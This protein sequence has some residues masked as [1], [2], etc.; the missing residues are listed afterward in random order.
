MLVE[1][2]REASYSAGK[3]SAHVGLV[4]EDARSGRSHAA[5]A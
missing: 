5:A 1:Q 3:L 4:I 2:C